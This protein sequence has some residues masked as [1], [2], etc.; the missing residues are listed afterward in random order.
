MYMLLQSMRRSNFIIAILTA[1]LFLCCIAYTDPSKGTLSYLLHEIS[2]FDYYREVHIEYLHIEERRFIS[3][4][5][6]GKS[7]HITYSP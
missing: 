6:D 4:G 1:M 5:F 2:H 7:K 3:V